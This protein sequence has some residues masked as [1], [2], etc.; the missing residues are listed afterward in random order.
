[1]QKIWYIS[2]VGLLIHRRMR[3]R[4][5]LINLINF[6]I[7]LFVSTRKFHLKAKNIPLEKYPTIKVRQINMLSNEHSFIA[8][9]PFDK[10]KM[11]IVN[12]RD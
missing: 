11:Y 3:F 1:M 12:D 6:N 8:S 10:F 2:P 4:P 5:I 7:W 9:F